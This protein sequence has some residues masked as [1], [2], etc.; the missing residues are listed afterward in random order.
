M[1][2]YPQLKNPKLYLV[3]LSDAAIFALAHIAAYLF[4]FELYLE[5]VYIKQI[6]TTLVWLIPLKLVVFFSADHIR[7]CGVTPVSGISGSLRRRH[8]YLP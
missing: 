7:A 2:I 4:R 8:F 1:K 3:L 6:E 5:P